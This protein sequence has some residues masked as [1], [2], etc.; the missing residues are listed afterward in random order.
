MCISQNFAH[1]IQKVGFGIK[2]SQIHSKKQPIIAVLGENLRHIAQNTQQERG[3]HVKSWQKGKNR[4]K[5]ID[6]YIFICYHM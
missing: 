5:S 3:L 6:K 1:F 4:K 2:K